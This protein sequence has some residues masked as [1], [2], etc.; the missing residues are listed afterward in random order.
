[1]INVSSPAS[2]LA[3][4]SLNPNRLRTVSL[5][6]FLIVWGGRKPSI[7]QRSARKVRR[8]PQDVAQSVDVRL[9]GVRAE[10]QG[11][12]AAGE[13]RVERIVGKLLHGNEPGRPELLQPVALI[14]Q[15]RPKRHSDGQIVRKHPRAEQTG[16]RRRV[17]WVQG[18]RLAA[19]H[20]KSDP[21]GQGSKQP[22]E[23]RPI[24]RQ[25]V[26][27][28]DQRGGR[29][30]RR[31]PRLVEAIERLTILRAVVAGRQRSGWRGLRLRA[32]PQADGAAREA[33]QEIA[34]CGLQPAS[35]LAGF[36]RS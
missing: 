15:R 2:R 33:H 17:T 28:R 18:R 11:D 1:L 12:V 24:L 16:V 23:P 10:L 31:H 22:L 5:P 25:N 26:E 20:Q 34:P 21:L 13:A 27:A 8:A 29:L 35:A 4:P 14:E 36:G 32:E 19:L 9:S 30:R 3:V 7:F 6:S